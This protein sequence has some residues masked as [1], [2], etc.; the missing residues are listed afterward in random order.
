MPIG[1]LIGECGV[2][3]ELARRYGKEGVV[4]A[5]FRYLRLCVLL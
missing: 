5:S 2:L 3:S 1:L 4:S